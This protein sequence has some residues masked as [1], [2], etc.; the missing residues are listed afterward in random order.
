MNDR[1]L[2]KYAVLGIIFDIGRY[3]NK[4]KET[5]D[6][7]KKEYYAQEIRK[8]KKDYTEIVNDLLGNPPENAG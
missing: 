1:D 6:K 7:R 8:M 2:K 4:I 3:E 5:T